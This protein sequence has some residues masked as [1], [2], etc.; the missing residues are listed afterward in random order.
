MSAETAVLT[1]TSLAPLVAT[2]SYSF[3][4]QV[5]AEGVATLWAPYKMRGPFDDQGVAEYPEQLAFLERWLAGR[6]CRG[7][8]STEW[9]FVDAAALKATATA[10]QAM[11]QPPAAKR[12]SATARRAVSAAE[13]R[14]WDAQVL[15]RFLDLVC[16]L[17]GAPRPG[18]VS[19]ENRVNTDAYEPSRRE[20][21][22]CGGLI[23][24]LEARGIASSIG[25]HGEE[26]SLTVAGLPSE[27]SV[28]GYSRID[29]RSGGEVEVAVRGVLDAQPQADG[30]I[31]SF[32]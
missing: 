15:T 24:T 19:I 23:V 14:A 12:P 31:A 6:P 2:R 7:T 32:A 21:W 13:A 8:W 10:L 29:M 18:F 20:V 26:A 30:F 22:V 16:A 25:V 1:G 27:I 5:T 3:F 11:L 28:T 17:S 9:T 4:T